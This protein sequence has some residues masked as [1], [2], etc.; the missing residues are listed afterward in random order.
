MKATIT[1]K[2]G[3][4]EITADV[5]NVRTSTIDRSL[6]LVQNARTEYI[7]DPFTHNKLEAF[8]D[9]EQ[10]AKYITWVKQ[11]S[12]AELKAQQDTPKAIDDYWA[13]LTDI[14]EGLSEMMQH[15]LTGKC[16]AEGKACNY[17]STVKVTNEQIT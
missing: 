2:F 13:G 10:Y 16:P 12:D 1:I 6:P 4:T 14:N 9:K 3:D 5:S 7:E 17:C 15:I 8:V 11:T